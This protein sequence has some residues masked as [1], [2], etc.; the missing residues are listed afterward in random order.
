MSALERAMAVEPMNFQNA[1]V[2]GEILRLQSWQGDDDY[3]ET[4]SKAMQ[5]FGRAI[6]LNRFHGS[7]YM[8]YGMCLDWVGRVQEARTYFERAIELDPNGYFVNAHM[9]WHYVQ[10]Q[11]YAAAREWLQRSLRLQ[12]TYNPIASSYLPIVKRK[13][14][15]GASEPVDMIAP[16]D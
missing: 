10:E 11:D 15:E 5:W 3:A 12:P 2:I 16:N 8:R 9:G 4:A 7:S 13:L 14:L 1:Y 6:Q